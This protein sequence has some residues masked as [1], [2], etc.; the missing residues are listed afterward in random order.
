MI[1]IILWYRENLFLAS[2][3]LIKYGVTFGGLLVEL[4]EMLWTLS[5][6]WCIVKDFDMTKIG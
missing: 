1:F 3:K 6:T 2:K 5:D 4:S